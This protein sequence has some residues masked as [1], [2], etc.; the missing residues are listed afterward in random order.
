MWQIQNF[1]STARFTCDFFEINCDNNKRKIYFQAI[2][3]Y[4]IYND[5]L[6][7]IKFDYFK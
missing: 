7:K 1:R 5:R 3:N 4:A 2:I 6:K